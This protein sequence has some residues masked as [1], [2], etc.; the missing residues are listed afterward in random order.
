MKNLV[1]NLVVKGKGVFRKTVVVVENVPQ[2]VDATATLALA[3]SAADSTSK[4]LMG[5]GTVCG[6]VA[7]VASSPVVSKIA[8]V[9]GASCFMS[10]FL[11]GF[12]KSMNEA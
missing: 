1:K 4:V 11:R 7:L 9:A 10:G 2:T 8:L 5:V 3:G 12:K 6:G